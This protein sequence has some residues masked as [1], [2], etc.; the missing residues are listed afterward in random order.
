LIESYV[1]TN[2]GPLSF[3]AKLP[4]RN[5]TTATFGPYAQ[6]NLRSLEN[7]P[8]GTAIYEDRDVFSVG[9]FFDNESDLQSSSLLVTYT[10][11]SESQPAEGHSKL[12][13]SIW[14]VHA[15]EGIKWR[16]LTLSGLFEFHHCLGISDRSDPFSILRAGPEI[17]WSAGRFSVGISGVL[18][19][20]RALATLDD[21]G[22]LAGHGA[23]HST[24]SAFLSGS[25]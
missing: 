6:F 17:K 12:I 24:L 14:S 18:T 10:A 4:L 5:E 2:L 15:H 13:G 9:M 22:D 21:L 23:G 20:N 19:L 7:E 3:T 8:Y 25:I 1:G 16:R 11:K